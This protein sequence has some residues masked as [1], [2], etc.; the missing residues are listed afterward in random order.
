MNP[1]V[2]QA[3]LLGYAALLV[4]GGLIGFLKA[5]SRPSLIAGVTSAIL[6]T[7]S[8]VAMSFDFRVGC[9]LG[10]L[11]AVS[12]AV[13]FGARLRRTRKWMPAGLML[14]VSQVVAVF[15]LV[16]LFA[17]VTRPS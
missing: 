13:F 14:I 4:V 9:A 12:L 17:G 11:L 3:V 10:A 1:V 6:A 7:L 8:A 2:A 5:K 15:L 16:A